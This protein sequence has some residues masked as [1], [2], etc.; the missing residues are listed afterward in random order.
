MRGKRPACTV[1]KLLLGRCFRCHQ[2]VDGNVHLKD[3]P[4]ELHCADCCVEC[5][6]TA[7]GDRPGDRAIHAFEAGTCRPLPQEDFCE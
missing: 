5:S 1:I 6:T 4:L 7:Q 3:D 2:M